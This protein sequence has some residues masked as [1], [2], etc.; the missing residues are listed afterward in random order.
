MPGVGFLIDSSSNPRAI[1][2]GSAMG[3]AGPVSF[4]FHSPPNDNPS[5]Y[6]Q[7]CFI[8]GVE[9]NDM[10]AH[11]YINADEAYESTCQQQ[12]EEGPPGEAATSDAEDSAPAT[13]NASESRQQ[14]PLLLGGLHRWARCVQVPA[15]PRRM[16]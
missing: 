11:G 3:E 8:E 5:E 7:A 10:Y 12:H 15:R 14:L 13:V 6:L 1:S 9:Q 4:I 16:Y 2:V